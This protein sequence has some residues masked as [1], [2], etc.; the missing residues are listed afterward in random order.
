MARCAVCGHQQPAGTLCAVCGFALHG[1]PVHGEPLQGGQSPARV[2]R[3]PSV[4]RAPEPPRG[5]CRQC[6]VL[7]EAERCPGCG[8]KVSFPDD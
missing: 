6:G 7:T 8:V 5:K 1:E 4:R 2:R 3:A